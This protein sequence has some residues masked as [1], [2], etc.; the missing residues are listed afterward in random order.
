MFPGQED[1]A[2]WLPTA[3]GNLCLQEP[4][5]VPQAWFQLRAE[6]LEQPRLKITDLKPERLGIT[7][8]NGWQK[9]RVRAE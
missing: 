4:G 3:G 1:A 6:N 8:A 9:N 2:A 7:H 5:R